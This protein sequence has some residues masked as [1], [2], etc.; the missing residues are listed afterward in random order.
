MLTKQPVMYSPI[1]RSCDGISWD[2]FCFSLGYY[3]KG[4]QTKWKSNRSQKGQGHEEQ[5]ACEE[6]ICRRAITGYTRGEDKGLLWRIWRGR[7]SC[8]LATKPLYCSLIHFTFQWSQW[9]LHLLK[10]VGKLIAVFGTYN[11]KI[12]FFFYRWNLLNYQWKIRQIKGEGS[13]LLLSKTKN[14]WR[15]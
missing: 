4:T 10:S 12:H 3:T 8:R 2:I 9:S 15:K 1:L 11:H 6:D 5:G 14:Q 13:V 7:R